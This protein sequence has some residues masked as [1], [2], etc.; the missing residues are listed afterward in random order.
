M[1]TADDDTFTS[2]VF[3][4]QPTGLIQPAGLHISLEIWQSGSVRSPMH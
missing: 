3:N 4:I 1:N 2:M